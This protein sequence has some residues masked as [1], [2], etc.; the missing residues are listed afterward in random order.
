M[1]ATISFKHRN[2]LTCGKKLMSFI[3]IIHVKK[4]V[5]HVFLEIIYLIPNKWLDVF[6]RRGQTILYTNTNPVVLY[7]LGLYKK[8]V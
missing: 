5:L 6:R 2:V 4:H 1:K 8:E 3:G 7:V